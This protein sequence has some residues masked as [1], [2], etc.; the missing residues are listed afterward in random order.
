MKTDITGTLYEDQYTF[1]IVSRSVL[2]RMRY[3]SEKGCRENQNTHFMFSNF[4]FQKPCPL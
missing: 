4:S 3:V 1:F 2:L